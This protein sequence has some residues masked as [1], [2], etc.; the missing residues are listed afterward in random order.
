MKTK[1][2]MVLKSAHFRKHVKICLI[3][4]TLSTLFILTALSLVL[5]FQFKKPKNPSPNEIFTNNIDSIVEVK[6]FSEN[7]G[8]SFGTAEFIN[9]DGS[10][11]TNAH[12]VTY[13]Y[14]NTTQTFEKYFIR[15]ASDE[16]YIEVSLVKYSP[17]LDIAILQMNPTIHKF[18]P[19]QIADSSK[20]K[21]GD[22]VYAIGNMAN[23]GI[24]MTEGIISSPLINIHY[25]N[26]TRSVIQCDLTIAEGNSG[27]SLVNSN[28]ELIGITT[29][30]TK[31]SGG[32]PIYGIAYCIPINA[33]LEYIK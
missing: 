29:F 19:M 22:K 13:S 25:N 20:I 26:I 12:V 24:S 6:A 23:Y 2:N 32:N 15:F 16:E 33:V 3:F 14:L 10:L 9:N 18:K 4:L 27:G 8:E 1:S 28:G 7:V 31:D 30:R 11:I 5:F 17:E 21:T